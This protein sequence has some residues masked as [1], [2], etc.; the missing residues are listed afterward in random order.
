[1]CA[2]KHGSGNHEQPPEVALTPSVH[3]DCDGDEECGQPQSIKDDPAIAAFEC[4]GH[5]AA[6]LASTRVILRREV[7]AGRR[8]QQCFLRITVFIP[9]KLASAVRSAA[10]TEGM[11]QDDLIVRALEEYLREQAELAIT[12]KLNDVYASCDSRLD[13]V[14][15]AMQFDAFRKWNEW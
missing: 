5:G 12:Q 9:N 8:P 6:F 14:L 1:M 10:A 11:P 13:P 4:N 7:G 3:P 15:E 2:N